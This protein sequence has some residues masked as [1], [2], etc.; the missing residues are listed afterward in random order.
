MLAART[1]RR[2]RLLPFGLGRR[3]CIGQQLA[4]AEMEA[5]LPLLARRGQV[6]VD[7]IPEPEPTFA[8]RRR[9]GLRGRFTA[10]AGQPA[11]VAAAG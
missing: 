3:G 6:V 9:G 5:G 2:W 10:G 11:G 7:R 1:R 8:L 4:L